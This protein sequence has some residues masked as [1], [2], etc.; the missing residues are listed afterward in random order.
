MAKSAS[1]CLSPALLIRTAAGTGWGNGAGSVSEDSSHAA[2]LQ[3]A[4]S[5]LRNADPL[6]APLIDDR[7]AF[8]FSAAF[9][10]AAGPPVA[11]LGSA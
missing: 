11:R 8:L 6:L 4:R 2:Y 5:Y 3:Q 1:I 10:P 9:E 7:P